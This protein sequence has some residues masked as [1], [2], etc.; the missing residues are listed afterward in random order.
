HRG[1]HAAYYPESTNIALKLIYN[2]ETLKILGAQAVGQEGTEKRIDVIATVMKLGGTIY[3]LQDM[4][5]SYAPPFSAAKDPVNILGYIAQNID[6]GVYKTVEWDEID[7]IVAGGG[8]LLDVRTP[9][10]FGAGHVDGAINLELDTIREN[11]DK[12]PSDK[13]APLY[14]TCQVGL[15]AYL[16]IRILAGHGYTNLWNLAGGYNTYKVGNYKL[17]PLNFEVKAETPG[18]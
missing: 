6:Q 15:R 18:E 8:T 12:L 13:N 2:P 3:D 17:A 4:E 14:V 7:D 5:L 16:A 10:E 9:I 1:N 11:L